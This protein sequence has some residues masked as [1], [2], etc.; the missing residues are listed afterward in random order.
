VVPVLN[1]GKEVSSAGGSDAMPLAIVVAFHPR[2]LP[3]AA[4]VARLPFKPGL[5]KPR[6]DSTSALTVQGAQR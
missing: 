4:A 3:T 5:W 1:E 6:I 2:R